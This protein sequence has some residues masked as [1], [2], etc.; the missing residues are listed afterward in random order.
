MEDIKK[1]N[2]IVNDIREKPQNPHISKVSDRGIS[3]CGGKKSPRYL[4][5][6]VEVRSFIRIVKP[7][8]KTI[9]YY[10]IIRKLR[11]RGYYYYQISN[12]FNQHGLKPNRTKCF[13][14]Q[15]IHGSYQKMKRRQKRMKEREL[16][17]VKNITYIY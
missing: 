9:P 7:P 16:P 12:I 2:K 5:V 15:L 1:R 11:D 4:L 3:I 13:T 10:R 6:D 8:P 14:P 17:V